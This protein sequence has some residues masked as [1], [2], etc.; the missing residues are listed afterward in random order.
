MRLLVVAHPDD[1]VIWFNPML[2]DRIII[3]FLGRADKPWMNEARI[4]ALSEHPLKA[5]ICCFYINESGYWKNKEQLRMHL[6]NFSKVTN[7][8]AEYLYED[9]YTEVFTHNA[10]GEYGHSDHI[11]VHEAVKQIFLYQGNIP[12]WV[13]VNSIT[14]AIIPGDN[15]FNNDLTMFKAIKDV[16]SRNKVWTWDSLFVPDKLQ[17]YR[18]ITL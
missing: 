6:D 9:L 8:L 7:A 18:Q 10:A 15:Y 4:K 12:M 5:K 2:F 1:E 13:Y 14:E 3:V 17:W 11:L 16:Y